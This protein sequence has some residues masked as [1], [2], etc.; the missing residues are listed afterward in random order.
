MIL[1]LMR[2]FSYPSLEAARAE[3]AEIFRLLAI[4][5]LGTPREPQQGDVMPDGW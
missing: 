4:E 1:T 2:Q 5:E 3:S